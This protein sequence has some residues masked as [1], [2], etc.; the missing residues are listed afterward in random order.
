MQ[1]YDRVGPQDLLVANPETLPIAR[2]NL[3]FRRTDSR[4]LPA[5]DPVAALPLRQPSGGVV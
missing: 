4:L 3:L 5:P 2:G 1:V